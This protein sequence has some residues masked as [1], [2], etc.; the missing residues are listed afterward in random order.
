[1]ALT[2]NPPGPP[3]ICKHLSCTIHEKD[4][5]GF[6]RCDIC[7]RL[8]RFEVYVTIM[9]K[10]INTNLQELRDEQTRLRLRVVDDSNGD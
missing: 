4:Q 2:N 1:M 8:M 3:I 10:N 5:A 9:L 7:S 6:V